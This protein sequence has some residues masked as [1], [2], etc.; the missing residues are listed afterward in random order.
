MHESPIKEQINNLVTLTFLQASD[1][2]TSSQVNRQNSIYDAQKSG[3][4]VGFCK[5]CPVLQCWSD[6]Q[7]RLFPKTAFLTI[8]EL[9]MVHSRSVVQAM[10][11]CDLHISTNI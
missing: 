9:R 11:T 10:W 2:P 7:Q 5:W 1:T 3:L 6:L 8:A 4:Y